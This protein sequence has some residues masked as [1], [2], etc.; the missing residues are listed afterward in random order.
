MRSFLLRYIP[1]NQTTLAVIL[2]IFIGLLLNLDVYQGR[3][4]TQ[5]S[6]GTGVSYF[7]LAGEAIVNVAFSFSFLEC[8]LLAVQFSLKFVLLS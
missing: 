4:D 3:F 7:T 6:H 5:I 2:S 1:K 8:Y